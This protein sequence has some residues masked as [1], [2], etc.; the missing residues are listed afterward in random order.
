MPTNINI[1]NAY[2]TQRRIQAWTWDTDN[3]YSTFVLLGAYVEFS[4]VPYPGAKTKPDGSAYVIGVDYPIPIRLNTH[5]DPVNHAAYFD[6]QPLSAR[7]EDYQEFA[8]NWFAETLV[9]GQLN[10]QKPSGNYPDDGANKKLPLSERAINMC[11]KIL[12]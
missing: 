8:I 5:V 4:N 2:P 6:N 7:S 1:M 11:L 10:P 9:G 3:I 12:S